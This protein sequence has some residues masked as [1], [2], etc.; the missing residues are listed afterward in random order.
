MSIF[1]EKY[2]LSHKEIFG[3]IENTLS[4]NQKYYTDVRIRCVISKKNDEWSNLLCL[5]KVLSK[6]IVDNV[7]KIKNIKY[8]ETHLLEEWIK[9]DKLIPFL[10][11]MTNNNF[12]LSEDKI[13]IDLSNEKW[14]LNLLPSNNEYMLN[15]GYI[16]QI[17]PKNK[18]NPSHKS[19]LSHNSPYY[20]DDYHAI[21]D[22]IELNPFHATSD[23]RIGN[24]ILILPECRAK[25]EDLK[26]NK[27][28]LIVSVKINDSSLEN[29]RVKGAWDTSE[30]IMQIDH[31]V[32]GSLIE[33]DLPSHFESLELC[34]MGPDDIVYDF[35]KETRLWASG[36]K[37]ILFTQITHS[38]DEDIVNHALNM[39]EG[40]TVEFKSYIYLDNQKL[41]EIFKT[42]VAFSNTAGGNIL[43]GVDKLCNIE[44][45]E[46][47]I[48]KEAHKKN[49]KTDEMYNKYIG[50]IKQNIADEL[51]EHVNIEIKKVEINQHVIILIKVPEGPSTPYFL[52]HTKQIYIRR[53]SNN[54]LP[55]PDNELPELLNKK[56]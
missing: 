49:I 48:A 4:N 25:F 56:Q 13:N 6:D 55:N 34:L 44:G 35:H 21:R 53:G 30:S 43:I 38:E 41:R 5:F 47:G 23:A 10:K 24:I 8:K 54:V 36:K 15:P 46:T 28:T 29:L 32:S 52:F 11:E 2:N 42:V 27:K 50:K 16:C 22:W 7:E 20:S 37:R 17:N 19:L 31:N 14:N 40:P 3:F 51:N 9:I 12:N 1:F 45:V 39:G 18:P 33:I 26:T